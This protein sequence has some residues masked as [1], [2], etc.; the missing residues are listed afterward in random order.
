MIQRLSSTVCVRGDAMR[1]VAN[2]ACARLRGVRC[3]QAKPGRRRC[4]LLPALAL[5]MLASFSDADCGAAMGSSEMACVALL[6]S[7]GAATSA[8][9][10]TSYSERVRASSAPPSP[11]RHDPWRF[12]RCVW[13]CVIAIACMRVGCTALEARFG[14]PKLRVRRVRTKSRRRVWY[15][16]IVTTKCCGCLSVGSVLPRRRSFRAR[17]YVRRRGNSRRR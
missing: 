13:I 2:A 10:S 9:P 6:L 17:G 14:W 15:P 5:A 4:V 7:G 1:R 11:L 3:R 16:E 8:P 12:L